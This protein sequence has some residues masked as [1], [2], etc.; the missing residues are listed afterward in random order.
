VNGLLARI[1]IAPSYSTVRASAAIPLLEESRLDAEEIAAVTEEL[2]EN[3]ILADIPQWTEW[4]DRHL[5]AT[6]AQQRMEKMF[7]H[8][9]GDSGNVSAVQEWLTTAPPGRL[10]DA[11]LRAVTV[12]LWEGN[13]DDGIRF[14]LS[15][16]D[17]GTRRSLLADI[18]ESWRRRGGN[19]ADK[20]AA[21]AFAAEHGLE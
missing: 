14:V 3:V 17:A 15:Q 18:L 19:S 12:S 16:P 13:R 9:S 7:V 20:E 6:T 4:L 11:A 21:E 5:P 10:R 1:L 2:H 8:C